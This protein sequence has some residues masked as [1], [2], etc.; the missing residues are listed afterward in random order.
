MEKYVLIYFKLKIF[1]T[2]KLLCSLLNVIFSYNR[3]KMAFKNTLIVIFIKC[4]QVEISFTKKELFS[5]MYSLE[6]ETVIN[7]CHI[8][9]KL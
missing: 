2:K 6:N 4:V 1:P 8:V 9:V 7:K 5:M 3:S